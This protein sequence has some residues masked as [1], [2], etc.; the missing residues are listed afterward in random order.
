MV[1]FCPDKQASGDIDFSDLAFE[2]EGKVGPRKLANGC[3]VFSSHVFKNN[4]MME[5]SLLLLFGS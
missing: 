2:G 4:V 3:A 1:W 5:F